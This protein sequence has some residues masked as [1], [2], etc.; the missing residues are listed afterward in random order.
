MNKILYDAEE[1]SQIVNLLNI[2]IVLLSALV[3]KELFDMIYKMILR[4]MR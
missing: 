4:Y 1:L 3:A 2:I